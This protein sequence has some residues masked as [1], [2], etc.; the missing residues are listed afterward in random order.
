MCERGEREREMSE[1][2]RVKPE[3]RVK[4]FSCRDV[5]GADSILSIIDVQKYP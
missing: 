4:T 1:S 3:T 2:E 5:C